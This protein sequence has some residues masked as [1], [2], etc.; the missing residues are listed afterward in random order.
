MWARKAA[1]LASRGDL[2][3]PVLLS[4]AA[5]LLT[6]LLIKQAHAYLTALHIW[7]DPE[8]LTLAYILPTIFITALFGSNIGVSTALISGLAADYFLYP[9]E[10]S[11]AIDDPKNVVE[12]GFFL[13]LSVSASKS[14]AVLTDE[15][16]LYRR[17]TRKLDRAALVTERRWRRF[18]PHL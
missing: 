1:A 8:D 5:V 17:P 16:P 4:I 2:I 18:A 14:T 11:F 6:S 7:H 9:P 13:A 12:L 3:A 15:K 10:F